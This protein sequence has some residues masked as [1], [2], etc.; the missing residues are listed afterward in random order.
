MSRGNSKLSSSV[1]MFSVN[2]VVDNRQ[3]F[4]CTNVFDSLLLF[5]Q[6]IAHH[7]YT[8]HRLHCNE[9]HSYF[10]YFC[11]KLFALKRKRK[12]ILEEN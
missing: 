8:Q 5:V 7:Q 11:C 10:Q 1:C 4:N 3:T 9:H 6:L 12:K 2:K